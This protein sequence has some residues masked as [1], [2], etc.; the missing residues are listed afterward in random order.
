MKALYTILLSVLFFSTLLAQFTKEYSYET[1][2]LHRLELDGEFVYVYEFDGSIFLHD[3]D[4][5]LIATLPMSECNQVISIHGVSKNKWGDT[6]TNT[7]VICVCENA[8]G[9]LEVIVAGENEIVHF[10]DDYKRRLRYDAEK[11]E[12]S[13]LD[14]ID[15]LHVIDLNDFSTKRIFTEENV[16]LIKSKNGETFYGGINANKELVLYDDEFNELQNT[17]TEDLK[18]GDFFSLTAFVLDDQEPAKITWGAITIDQ[19][20]QG[21]M[22][23][24]DLEGNDLGTIKGFAGI[25]YTEERTLLIGYENVED[26]MSIYDLAS[27]E[28]L[29]EVQFP[30]GLK[31]WGG[32]TFII[33][34]FQDLA[35]NQV[36]FINDDLELHAM[37]EYSCTAEWCTPGYFVD[38]YDRFFWTLTES[39]DLIKV[40]MGEEEVARFEN[41]SFLFLN[42]LE[43]HPDKLITILQISEDNRIFDVYSINDPTVPVEE[44]SLHAFEI[45]PNPVDQTLYLENPNAEDILSIELLT[46]TGKSIRTF[47][48]FGTSKKV[49]LNLPAL[50]AGLY[51]LSIKTSDGVQSMKVLK[52]R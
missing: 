42:K 16:S 26:K 37:Y 52:S 1:N 45:Y 4:H 10:K 9:T 35:K 49:A 29:N 41:R 50:T 31:G 11:N 22:V 46:L 14:R 34:Y 40:M 28:K 24:I 6:P 30:E 48:E 39:T 33:Y 18:Y 36:S 27:L 12:F 5:E 21:I 20:F 8:P 3:S 25:K 51:T 15:N 17:P 43:N 2:Q 13:Y 7:D 19:N 23:L 44:S 38:S 32:T 47:T